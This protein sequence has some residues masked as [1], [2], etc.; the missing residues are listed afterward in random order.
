M[1]K[2][3]LQI[4]YLVLSFFLFFKPDCLYANDLGTVVKVDQGDIVWSQSNG[5]PSL[6]EGQ[7]YFSTFLKQKDKWSAPVK[8]TNDQFRNGHPSIDAGA[9][10][11]K[12]LVWVAGIQSEYKIHY[13]I[14]TNN[15]WS[16][17]GVI[18]SS[19]SVNLS[20]SVLVDGTG[21]TWAVWSGNNGGQDEIYY[22]RYLGNAWT[23][24]MRI[25]AE[26]NVPDIFPAISLNQNKVPQ[27]T[28]YGYR[29][30]AYEKLQ[31]TWEG[32]AWSKE[33]VI[34]GSSQELSQGSPQSKGTQVNATIANMPS[35]IAQPER[36]F[37]RVYKSS[38][39][40]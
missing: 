34:Q 1:R 33:V 30:G 26:N 2:A 8:V 5:S 27:V 17:P 3:L 12:W 36:A 11:K 39:V 7:I 15:S 40:K 9:D 28:W 16:K 32:N 20:P 19:L 37:I 25:N 29:N 13:S 38:I 4:G 22:S 14:G 31:S 10:G 6:H 24:P 35:F 21:T 18:P 23:T